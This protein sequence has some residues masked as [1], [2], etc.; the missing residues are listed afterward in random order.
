MGY[1]CRQSIYGIYIYT[2]YPVGYHS[3]SLTSCLY[4]MSMYIQNGHVLSAAECLL[5]SLWSAHVG[6]CL[7]ID[8][9]SGFSFNYT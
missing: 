8:A 3:D 7:V 6:R 2:V 5:L 9:V 4:S 1:R